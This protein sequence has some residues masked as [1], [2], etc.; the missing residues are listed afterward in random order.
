M[1]HVLSIYRKRGFI[2]KTVLMDG[3]FEPLRGDLADLQLKLNTVSNDERVPEV[4]VAFAQ[5]RSALAAST[6]PYRSSASPFD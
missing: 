1:T 5:S 4:E 6:T 3:Q 2:V